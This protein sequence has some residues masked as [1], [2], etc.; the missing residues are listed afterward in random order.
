M[1][2]LA[3]LAVAA[4]VAIVGKTSA[5]APVSTTVAAK[6]VTQ[7]VSEPSYSA[8]ADT[9]TGEALP[10][11]TTAAEAAKVESDIRIV[12][13]LSGSTATPTSVTLS[14]PAQAQAGTP[15]APGTASAGPSGVPSAPGPTVPFEYIPPE[16]SDPAFAQMYLNG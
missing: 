4:L 8:L 12:G 13:T 2:L 15:V 11:W 6:T 1:P 3:I 14:N 10:P 16:I 5:T 7:V 9:A